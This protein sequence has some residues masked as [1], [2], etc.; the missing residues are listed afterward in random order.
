MRF[1]GRFND[2]SETELLLSVNGALIKINA[3]LF[4]RAQADA[5]ARCTKA[6]R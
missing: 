4:Y 2:F 3:A 5:L 6:A 1:R